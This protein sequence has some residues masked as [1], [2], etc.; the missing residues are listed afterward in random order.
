MPRDGERYTT[1]IL[2][3]KKIAGVTIPISDK[4]DFRTSLIISEKEDYFIT[5]M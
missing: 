2:T 3:K 5:I 1:L 4:V